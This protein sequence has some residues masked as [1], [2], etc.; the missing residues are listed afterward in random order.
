MHMIKMYLFK[1]LSMGEYNAQKCGP[2]VFN[3]H[4]EFF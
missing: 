1:N 4:L 3:L 2:E